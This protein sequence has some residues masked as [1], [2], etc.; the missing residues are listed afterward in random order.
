MR[1]VEVT[2]G[3]GGG[4][5]P[6]RGA[7]RRENA[8]RKLGRSKRRTVGQCRT[9][10]VILPDPQHER[11]GGTGRGARGGGYDPRVAPVAPADL[12]AHADPAQDRAAA[13]LLAV[14]DA[15]A[16][17]DRTRGGAGADVRVREAPERDAEAR[18]R[19]DVRVDRGGDGRVE[20][21][22]GADAVHREELRRAQARGAAAVGGGVPRVHRAI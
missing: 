10:H 3:G 19:G 11:V 4:D 14:R 5:G 1:A 13:A 7:R 12:A 21:G 8:K 17:P 16:S 20:D 18:D 22:C 15:R 6:A 9:R 2:G